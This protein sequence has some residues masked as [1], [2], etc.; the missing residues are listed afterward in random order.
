MRE[1]T[2]LT[3]LREPEPERLFPQLVAVPA[4]EG[5]NDGPHRGV[6]GGYDGANC[7]VIAGAA[8]IARTGPAVRRRF[9]FLCL[10]G[11]GKEEFPADTAVD[12]IPGEGL[13]RR[14]FSE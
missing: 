14:P 12:A 9:A 4:G 5:G 7:P 3:K 2:G 6:R 10:F 1:K 11:L 8:L 13:R